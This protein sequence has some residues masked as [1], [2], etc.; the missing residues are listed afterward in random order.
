MFSPSSNQT[1]T[2]DFYVKTQGMCLFACRVTNLRLNQASVSFI[3]QGKLQAVN[4]FSGLAPY[5]LEEIFANLCFGGQVGSGCS[6]ASYCCY[7]EGS[8]A[9]STVNYSPFPSLLLHPFGFGGFGC[10]ADTSPGESG[11]SPT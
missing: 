2:T 1:L 9:F 7:G 8:I 6:I 3:A 10:K 4:S 11:S 5:I